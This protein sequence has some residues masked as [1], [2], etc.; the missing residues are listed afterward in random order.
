MRLDTHGGDNVADHTVST[1][2]YGT[3]F[4]GFKGFS[5]WTADVFDWEANMAA[6]PKNNITSSY[7][8]FGASAGHKTFDSAAT[9]TTNRYVGLVPDWNI[10]KDVYDK[11]DIFDDFENISMKWVT[12]IDDDPPTGA[13]RYMGQ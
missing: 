1:E 13:E 6:T 2:D 8:P 7:M 10:T 4:E 3:S 5:P 9:A 11:Q 12:R